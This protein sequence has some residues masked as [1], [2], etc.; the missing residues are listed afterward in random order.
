M[1]CKY[2]QNFWTMILN[3]FGWHL[4]F[5]KEVKDFFGYDLNV[6]PFQERKSPIMEKPHHDFLLESVER[7][8]LENICRNDTDLHKTFR[9][10]CLPSYILV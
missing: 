4:T 3:I 2:T 5:P 9:Q 8:Q 10:C 6:P 7:K 1:E